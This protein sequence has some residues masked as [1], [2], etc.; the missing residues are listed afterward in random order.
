MTEVPV[1]LQRERNEAW[2]DSLASENISG[3]YLILFIR[4]FAWRYNDK[5][6]Y[7]LKIFTVIS[8]TYSLSFMQ[9]RKSNIKEIV[10][11]QDLFFI[12]FI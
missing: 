3:R 10:G 4:D 8:S 12:I 5:F 11:S 1:H 9:K 2:M 7:L 6:F